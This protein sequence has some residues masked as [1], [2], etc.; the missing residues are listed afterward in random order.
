DFL[1]ESHL[2]FPMRGKA[3][4]TVP[5][6]RPEDAEG[7]LQRLAWRGQPFECPSTHGTRIIV[8]FAH[9]LDDRPLIRQRTRLALLGKGTGGQ[10]P[11]RIEAMLFQEI[12]GQ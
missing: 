8:P 4:V 3:T 11:L 7:V 12:I 2:Q 10:I 5:W 1:G 6:A 9:E